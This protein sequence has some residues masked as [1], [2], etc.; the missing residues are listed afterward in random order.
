[1]K[2]KDVIRRLSNK[3]YITTLNIIYINKGLITVYTR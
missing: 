1:M 3:V 2:G